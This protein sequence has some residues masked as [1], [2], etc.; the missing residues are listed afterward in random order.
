MIKFGTYTFYENYFLRL[1][2]RNNNYTIIFDGTS[3]PFGDFEKHSENI[4]F[5][6]VQ[7]HEIS[8]AVFIKTKCVYKNYEFD[9]IPLNE[10]KMAIVTDSKDACEKLNLET[11][12]MGVYQKEVERKELERIWEIRSVSI[13]GLPMPNG[14]ELI[15]EIEV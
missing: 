14:I 12:E 5:K 9:L 11:R 13:F 10:N 8:N 3:C 6:I 1:L 2:D 4:F 15:K 7:K